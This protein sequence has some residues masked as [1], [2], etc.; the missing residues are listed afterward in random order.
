YIRARCSRATRPPSSRTSRASPRNSPPPAA[1]HALHQRPAPSLSALVSALSSL[2]SAGSVGCLSAPT[3]AAHPG[4]RIACSLAFFRKEH[5]VPFRSD[6]PG[7]PETQVGRWHAMRMKDEGRRRRG[8]LTEDVDWEKVWGRSMKDNVVPPALRGLGKRDVHTIV[9]LTDGA[10]QGLNESL[11]SFPLATKLG[12]FCSSTPFVT[13]RPYTLLHNGSVASSGAVGIALSAGLRPALQNSYP[14]LHAITRPLKVTAS[15]GNL[16]NE[17]DNRNPT[18][19]LISAMD[20]TAL[21]GRGAKDNEFYLG[22]LRDG[23][24]WQVHHIMA[25]GPSRGTM[26]LETETAPRWGHP[27]RCVRLSSLATA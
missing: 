14:G 17:L 19:L 1:L 18:A 3:T 20:E 4:A 13:G 15:E 27:S 11:S 7:R 2:S 23:D 12:L 21:T 8:E 16:V 10:P 5:A 24:L 25:G 6:I 22:V 26:A 9:T